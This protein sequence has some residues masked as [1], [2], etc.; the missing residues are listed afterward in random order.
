MYFSRKTPFCINECSFSNI[1]Y[2]LI[3]SQDSTLPEI[4][5]LLRSFSQLHF[6]VFYC[7]CS[8]LGHNNENNNTIC[9]DYTCTKSKCSNYLNYITNFTYIIVTTIIIIVCCLI[10]SFWYV[11]FR[12]RYSQ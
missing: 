7:F 12:C 1:Y 4:Y 9:F 11:K 3:G 5:I 10:H 8:K 6:R 2:A